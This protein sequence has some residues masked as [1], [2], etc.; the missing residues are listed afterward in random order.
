MPE[1][2]LIQDRFKDSLA[3]G[4]VRVMRLQH[5]HT[6]AWQ[7]HETPPK[8]SRCSHAR[9]MWWATAAVGAS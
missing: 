2:L 4:R 7:R 6:T 8:R 1:L 3:R 9:S 5:R